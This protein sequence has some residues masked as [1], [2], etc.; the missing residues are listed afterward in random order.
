MK[1]FVTLAMKFASVVNV[2][3]VTFP[4]P[5]LGTIIRTPLRLFRLF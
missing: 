3:T 2:I 4:D 1:V 5:R